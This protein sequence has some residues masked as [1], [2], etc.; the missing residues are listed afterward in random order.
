[1]E[2]NNHSY[3][4]DELNHLNNE[5]NRQMVEK[6]DYEKVLIPPSGPQSVPILSDEIKSH[7]INLDANLN[8]FSSI[9]EIK[10]DYYLIDFIQPRTLRS[11][12]GFGH[13][14]LGKGRHVSPYTIKITS[15][16]AINVHC[17]LIHGS[18]DSNGLESDIIYSFPAYKVPVGAKINEH[19]STLMFLPVSH[20]VIK[21]LRFRI[22]DNNAKELDFKEEECAFCIRLCQ[23]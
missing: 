15:A 4:A 12:L 20:S 8:T 7:Y 17:D 3:G 11:I 6:K 18:Y 19:P 14:I 13:V 2:D 21:Q 9:L 10:N 5:I 23:V 22:T 1:M 16:K